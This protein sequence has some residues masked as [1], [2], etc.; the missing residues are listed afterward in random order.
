MRTLLVYGP[1][2]DPLSFFGNL[3]RTYGDLAHVHMAGEHVYLVN[4]PRA[5]R[6]ILV[7]D[8]RL[9][10]KGRGLD[11]AKRLLGEGLLTSEG[12]VHVRQRRLMQPAFHR[13]RIASYASVMTE[14]SDR[15]RRGWT[16]GGT[17]DA[18]QDMARLTL[19]VVGKTLFDADVESQAKEVGKALAATM[20]SFWMLMLPFP[21]LLERL[22]IPALRRSRA[23][24]ET[25]DRIIYAMIAERRTSPSDR[26]DLL[27][28]LLM[29]QDE[30][31]GGQGMSDLEVRDEAMTIFLAGHE[32]TANALAWTWYLLSQTP[33]VEAALHEEIDRVLGGRLPTVAD[34]PALP[35]VEKVVTESM[36]LY[37]PAWI[38]GRRA[39]EDYE[40]GEYLIPARSI[41]VMSPYL[42]HRDA[43]Y[44]PD[45]ERFWPD[46]W[47]AEFKARL[48][49]FAYFP[50][51][52]GAR[53]CI[54]ESF[55]WMELVLVVSTI[56]Q[57]WRLRL[58][59]GRSVVPQPVVTLRVKG[60]LRMNTQLRIKN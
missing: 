36:R 3:A 2:R 5:I 57:R 53:R 10:M 48:Q 45:P 21:D 33:E 24:R 27:S 28:M 38:I 55:A 43:R 56:A 50:F 8:Q 14:F 44:F 51:G 23:A 40:V 54:G 13:D 31:A 58:V 52:G 12:A 18:A 32:T 39:L 25:L 49:P 11:R 30:E 15:V 29:A 22:P 19:G 7:T 37:P 16:D 41:V 26:G 35:F 60:G 6:D 42:V 20:E 59:P 9:F 34:I 46:R 17:I 47:T 4:D 1:G